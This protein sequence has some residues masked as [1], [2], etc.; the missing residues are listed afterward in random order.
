M[1][2]IPE[3]IAPLTRDNLH[4]LGCSYSLREMARDE[5]CP[6]CGWPVGKTIAGQWPPL[7]MRLKLMSRFMI[8]ISTSLLVM[9]LFNEYM[10]RPVG[11]VKYR[12]IWHNYWVIHD[13]SGWVLVFLIPLAVFTLCIGP[14]RR[15]RT[16]WI[17]LL[18]SSLV[19][20]MILTT[21]YLTWK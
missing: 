13:I 14:L 17:P 4:C 9:T 6:E 3:Q 19:L 12:G 7:P 10:F 8:L 15:R 11:D 2:A 5:N 20:V 16:F 1:P 21:D 18:F